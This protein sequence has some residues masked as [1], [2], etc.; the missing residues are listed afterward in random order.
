M[1]MEYMNLLRHGY[2]HNPN[3]SPY[4][5]PPHG[6][7]GHSYQYMYTEEQLYMM[8]HL[9][10]RAMMGAGAPQGNGQQGKLPTDPKPRLSKEEVDLLEHE[11]QKNSKPSS[12][13]KRE[14][15]DHLK[16]DHPRINVG[17]STVPS[18]P[19]G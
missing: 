6:L 7:G 2:Q 8:A 14:I 10:H 12:G 5:G 4:D 11:F 17:C 16:V 19:R 3:M 18:H 1:A 15:A 13:R 9:Q